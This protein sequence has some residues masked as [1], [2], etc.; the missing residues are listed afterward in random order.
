M[1]KTIIGI[2]VTIIAVSGVYLI[3]LKKVEE[4]YNVQLEEVKNSYE[5]QISNMKEQY[6]ESY[7]ELENE[8]DNLQTQV[9]N[10]METNKPYEI[11]VEHDGKRHTW[12]NKEGKRGL[13]NSKKHVICY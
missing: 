8:M 5:T 3:E 10:Y 9:Y 13:F 7:S 12:Y 2:L 6:K 1:K 4:N 11:T